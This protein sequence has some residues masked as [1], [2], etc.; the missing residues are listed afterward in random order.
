MWHREHSVV[1][2]TTKEAVWSLWTNPENWPKYDPTISEA[3]FHG[4][5]AVGVEGKMKAASSDKVINF[6]LTELVE[7]ERMTIQ[8]KKFG[9]RVLGIHMVDDAEDGVKIT[10]RVELRGLFSWFHRS[11][12]KKG[13]GGH[14]EEIVKQMAEAVLALEKSAPAPKKKDDD[15]DEAQADAEAPEGVEGDP[16]E[17]EKRKKDMHEQIEEAAEAE[18][19]EVEKPKPL[20]EEESEAD[21]EEKVAEEAASEEK[22]EAPAKDDSD[23]AVEEPAQEEEKAEDTSEEAPAETPEENPENDAPRPEAADKEAAEEPAEAVEDKAEVT[24]KE[25]E[26]KEK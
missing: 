9:A 23:K 13:I 4:D 3:A 8:V 10:F 26:S 2:K 22:I 16:E 19:P 12:V 1:V 25:A 11:S 17:N 15:A 6:S 21:A 20:V 24:D 7:N 14:A 5:L 18:V